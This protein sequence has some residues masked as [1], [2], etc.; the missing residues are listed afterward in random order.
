MVGGCRSD[1][2]PIK[3]ANNLPAEA[4]QS[5][6]NGIAS[7]YISSLGDGGEAGTSSV[8]LAMEAASAAK[9]SSTF[10]NSI[11]GS[12][13]AS[14]AD[15]SRGARFTGTAEGDGQ[16]TGVGL[17]SVR[18]RWAGGGGSGSGPVSRKSSITRWRAVRPN[19][20]SDLRLSRLRAARE[21]NSRA[22]VGEQNCSP[23]RGVKLLPQYWHSA[24]WTSIHLHHGPDGTRLL[25]S[26]ALILTLQILRE[27]LSH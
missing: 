18:V 11:V 4:M 20:V 9:P 13:S 5:E 24:I 1:S 2:W 26:K 15:R 6:A 12:F 25:P 16:K 17:N 27:Y 19:L 22:C 7:A 21:K 3:A 23:I 14:G 8:R 10:N